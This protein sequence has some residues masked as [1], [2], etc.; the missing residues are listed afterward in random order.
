MLDMGFKPQVDRIV[1]HIPENRQT[2]LFSATLAGPVEELAAA[3]T[4]NP[5]RVRAEAPAEKASGQ[6]THTF[7]GVNA[8][9]KVDRLVEQLN[10]ADGLAIVFVRTKHGADKLARRLGKHAIDAVALHGNMSQNQRQRALARF[11]SGRVGTLVATDVAARGLDV[12][13][14]S[15]VINFDPPTVDADYVHR[16]GRTG[17]AGRSGTGVTLVLPDQQ[18]DVGRLA[19][20]LGQGMQFSAAG[21]AVPK[22]TPAS[23]PKSQRRRAPR[24]RR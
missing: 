18:N 5:V 12:D 3:Y 21:L 7:V 24:T 11:A 4:S 20:R 13:D 6:I 19:G 16:I 15:H 23:R 1:R 8:E 10:A 17:R 9:N 2:M 14:I 22:S